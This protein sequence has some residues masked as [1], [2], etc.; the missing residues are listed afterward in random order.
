MK[1]QVGMK[2][3]R[4]NYDL[5]DSFKVGDC[6]V[7]VQLDNDENVYVI[8]EK[9]EQYMG[10]HKLHKGPKGSS[11]VKPENLKPAPSK[12]HKALA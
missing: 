11:G 4:I 7:V 3:Q 9:I 12:L 5:D 6:A 2:V 8:N 1:L 10:M